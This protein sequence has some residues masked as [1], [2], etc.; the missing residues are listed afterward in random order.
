MAIRT[1]GMDFQSRVPLPG[2]LPEDYD[3]WRS[4]YGK[5]LTSGHRSRKLM[6]YLLM[7][8]VVV[9]TK[10]IVVHNFTMGDVDDPDLY[11][12]EPLWEWQNTVQGKWVMENA[13]ESPVWSRMADPLTFGHRYII[14]ATFIEKKVTEYY[15][16]FGNEA[17]KIMRG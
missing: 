12:A 13:L 15:L 6:E 10:E 7:D 17:G 14:T 8:E 5:I 4:N 2:L 11:A 3:E 1:H 9:I 16:R